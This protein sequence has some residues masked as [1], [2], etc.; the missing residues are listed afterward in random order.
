MQCSKSFRLRPRHAAP[1]K[2][3]E[4]VSRLGVFKNN[5]H[6][7]VTTIIELTTAFFGGGGAGG[8]GDRGPTGG[9][10]I[11]TCSFAREAYDASVIL[12]AGA[13]ICLASVK[14]IVGRYLEYR[15]VLEPRMPHCALPGRLQW[16]YVSKVG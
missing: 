10:P 1:E 2:R 7:V 5:E 13:S 3:C 9:E 15:P 12:K 11:F 4:Y 6:I 16:L 14:R 8:S